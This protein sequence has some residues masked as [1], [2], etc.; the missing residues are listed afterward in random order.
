MNEEIMERIIRENIFKK[1]MLLLL[2]SKKSG[3]KLLLN[4]LKVCGLQA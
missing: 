2:F 1:N 4:M 3:G